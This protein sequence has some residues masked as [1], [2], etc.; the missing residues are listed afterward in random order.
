MRNGSLSGLEQVILAPKFAAV[1]AALVALIE[2]AA[3]FNAGTTA[4]PHLAVSLTIP[5]I[6]FVYF[7]NELFLRELRAI[8][9]DLP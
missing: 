8:A 2:N 6:D 4:A 3:A 1:D 5:K 9:Q 7:R